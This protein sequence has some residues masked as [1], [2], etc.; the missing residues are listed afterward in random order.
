MKII[1]IVITCIFAFIILGAVGYGL[2]ILFFPVH[3]L[4]NEIQTAN[5]TIDKTVNADNAIYNYEWFKQ[6]KEDIDAAGKKLIIAKNAE[7]SYATKIS[8]C[9]KNGENCKISAGAWSFS[10]GNEDSRLLAVAQGIDSNLQD[11]IAT[12]NARSKMAN[13]A[14]FQNGIL[15]NF[16]DATTFIFKP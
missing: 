15:P 3:V 2:K 9:D 1:G 7:L 5:D 8:D 14:I 13:R 6:Q 4:D 12:Y 16:I 10:Q 11:M